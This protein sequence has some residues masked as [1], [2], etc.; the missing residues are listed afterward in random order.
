MDIRCEE[1]G[2]WVR[3]PQNVE[4]RPVTERSRVNE[5]P[6]GFLIAKL[7]FGRNN[8]AMEYDLGFTSCKGE[9]PYKAIVVSYPKCKWNIDFSFGYKGEYDHSKLRE[10]YGEKQVAHYNGISGKGKWLS[11]IKGGYTYDATTEE[12]EQEI[13][14]EEL[15]TALKGKWAFLSELETFFEPI[16]GFL[17][18][19]LGYSKDGEKAYEAN[20]THLTKRK[21]DTSEHT[22]ATVDIQWPNFTLRGGWERKEFSDGSV[23]GEGSFTIAFNPLIGITGKIDIIQFAL[24]TL[25]GGFGT[26]IRKVTNMSLGKKDEDG[27]LTKEGAYF[28]TKLSLTIGAE[29]KISGALNFTS[30][31]E[32]GWHTDAGGTGISGTVGFILQGEIKGEGGATHGKKDE[33]MYFEVKFGI[34]ALFKTTDESG[35]KN[36]AIEMD[37]KPT[38]IDEHFVWVGKAAFNGLAIVWSVYA[39][40]GVDAGEEKSLGK[41]V[42]KPVMGKVKAKKQKLKTQKPHVLF[43]KRELF[44]TKSVG[45]VGV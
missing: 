37:Y 25:G 15:I 44:S 18:A 34:G 7:I 8:D 33:G 39:N 12:I 31:Q 6:I 1:T 32:K 16:N 11:S 41:D 3:R 35:S 36:A 13:N 19:G 20:K 27:K 17:E 28:E 26:F 42:N 9:H 45:R 4:F 43:K 14:A 22:I 21:K 29:S 38:V 30:N 10:Y 23:G 5:N 40:G 2:T 24:A